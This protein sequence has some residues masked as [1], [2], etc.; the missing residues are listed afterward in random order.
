MLCSTD[1]PSGFLV[2]VFFELPESAFC[3]LQIAEI[4]IEWDEIPQKC[5]QKSTFYMAYSKSYHIFMS[6][7]F[8]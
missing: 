3:G 6:Y 5:T 7:L 4:I 8:D 2:N 1:L